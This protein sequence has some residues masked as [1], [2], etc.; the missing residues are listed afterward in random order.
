MKIKGIILPTIL[1]TI[2]VYIIYNLDYITDYTVKLI[3]P[4]PTVHPDPPNDFVTNNDFLYVQKTNNFTPYSK[5]ELINII[6]TILD[7]GYQKFT[8]Y[9][10]SEYSECVEDFT[11]IIS[12][13]PLI[14]NIGDFTNPYNNF[15]D[16]NVTTWSHGQIDVEVSKMYESK[17]IHEMNDKINDILDEIITDDMKLEDKILKVHDYIID[18]T[19]YDVDSV[20]NGDAY[21]LIMNHKAKCSGYADIMAIILNKF[22]VKNYRVASNNHIWNAAY[23][24]NKWYHIDLTWDDPVVEGNTTITDTIRHK[25]YMID[26]ETL[27]S[28]DTEEHNFDENVFQEL[29]RLEN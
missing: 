27:L 4:T 10:P 5:T 3:S 22:G 18:E 25:F 11:N 20:T 21:N 8:F 29:K 12:N 7:N 13:K 26:T 23:I 28:Y 14:S 24:D 9:C 6:Y 17:Q 16:L 19:T 1:I 2:L 15:I